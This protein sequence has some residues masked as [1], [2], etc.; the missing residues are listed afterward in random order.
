[1]IRRRGADKLQDTRPEQ[2]LDALAEHMGLKLSRSAPIA[3]LGSGAAFRPDRQIEGT[4]ILIHVDGPPSHHTKR[5]VAKGDWQDRKL[6]E[7][8][9]RNLRVPAELLKKKW[10]GYTGWVIRAFMSSD[11][12]NFRLDA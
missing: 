4:N 10:W 1:M 3:V 5:G 12:P 7:M 11:E 6:N 8:G 2:A 9:W